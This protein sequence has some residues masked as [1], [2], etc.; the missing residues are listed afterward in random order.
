MPLE[1]VISPLAD[2][3]P[4]LE[5]RLEPAI[6]DLRFRD[7]QEDAPLMRTFFSQSSSGT[8]ATSGFGRRAAAPRPGARRRV[9]ELRRELRRQKKISSLLAKSRGAAARDPRV[10][11]RRRFLRG[12]TALWFLEQL[13]GSRPRPTTLTAFFVD[14]PLDAP[15]SRPRSA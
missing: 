8:P 15:C 10:D 2:S 9:S 4:G 12:A 14:G 1:R 5:Q 3:R 6:I 11:R 7:R 13:R